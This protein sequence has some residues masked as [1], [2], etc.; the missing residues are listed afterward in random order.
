MAPRADRKLAAIIAVD[1]VGYSRLVGADEAGALARVKAYRRDFAVPLIAEFRGRVVRLTGDGMLVEFE[2]AVDAVEC[3]VAIQA[4]MAEREAAEPELRRIRYRIGINIGDVVHEDGDILGDGVNVAARLEGLAEPGGICIARNVYSQVKNKLAFDFVA[5]GAH[6][7]KNIAEPV[8]VWRVLWA[9][10]AAPADAL[11]QHKSLKPSGGWARGAGGAAAV[12]LVASVATWWS[13][14]LPGFRAPV[15]GESHSRA[16]IKQAASPTYQPTLVVLPFANLGGDADQAYFADGMT[17]DLITDLSQFRGLAVIGRNST[18]SRRVR[19]APLDEV[20]RE[21][22]VDYVLQGSVQRSGVRVRINVELTD[23][24]RQAQLWAG[25]YDGVLNDVFALQDQVTEQIIAAL[26][27]ELPDWGTVY[28][29]NKEIKNPISYDL[30][31]QGWAHYWRNTP[32]DFVKAIGYLEQ[33]LRYDPGYGRAQA[34]L[35]AVYWSAWEQEWEQGL[36]LTAEETLAR[37]KSHLD[38]ALGSHSALAHMVA[39]EM[40]TAQGYHDRAI[41]EADRAIAAEPGSA[42]GFYAKGVALVMSGAPRDAEQLL[43]KAMR[44]DPYSGA[45]LFWLALAQFD[46]ERFEQA[47]TTLK[48]AIDRNPEDDWPYLLL[49]STLGHLERP[50]EAKSALDQFDRLSRSRRAWSSRH[51]PYVHSWAFRDQRDTQRLV[52]GLKK[53]GLEL[54]FRT[55]VR[56]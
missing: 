36:G 28:S 56:R 54:G 14:G 51:L 1:V 11:P 31:L 42:V 9:G 44:L 53:A 20:A 33:A 4:G 8:E 24:R 21:L 25:R 40:L 17:E 5:M 45:Y 2:S 34:T 10:P 47:A 19:S 6:R 15:G 37:A 27:E 52:M 32:A 46:T 50:K 29:G 23:V 43:R 35:A 18:F 12:L 49:A 41:A 30:F 55:A 38:A 39:A 26:T 7:V 22:G 16:A 13:A 48:L 3:V